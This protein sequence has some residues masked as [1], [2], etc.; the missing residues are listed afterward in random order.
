V[1]EKSKEQEGK[2][3]GGEA[4]GDEGSGLSY[5]CT[6]RYEAIE[7]NSTW[8]DMEIDTHAHIDI[9]IDIDTHVDRVR[10]V[11]SYPETDV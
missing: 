9:D 4:R 2:G 5:G 8:T 11:H 6:L 1:R 3:R 10:P 7:G